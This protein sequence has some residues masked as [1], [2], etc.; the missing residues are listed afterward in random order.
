M[1]LALALTSAEREH[2]KHQGIVTYIAPLSVK[3]GRPLITAIQQAVAKQRQ[4][5]LRKAYDHLRYKTMHPATIHAADPCLALAD[6]YLRHLTENEN[7]PG[8]MRAYCKLYK[9]T[10]SILRLALSAKRLAEEPTL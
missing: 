3:R 7:R 2:L 1:T 9:T 5:E 10:P 4:E 8:T 6:H